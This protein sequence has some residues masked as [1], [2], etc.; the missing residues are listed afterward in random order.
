MRPADPHLTPQEL[1]LVLLS[2]A[3]PNLTTA[4][5]AQ[6]QEAQGHLERCEYCRSVAKQYANIDSALGRLR[7]GANPVRKKDCPEESVWL[8]VAAGL[9]DKGQ[10]AKLLEHA[11]QC[12]YCG[13]LLREAAEDLAA[14]PDKEIEAAVA[15]L[16]AAQ[17]DRQRALAAKLAK[18]PGAEGPRTAQEVGAGKSG[19][20]RPR[21]VWWPRLVWAAAGF[22]VLAVAA[23][24]G[25]KMLRQP[26]PNNL[27]AKAFTKKRTIEL[28]FPGAA[29]GPMRVERGSGN[30]DQPTEFYEAEVI[31]KRESGKHAEDPK[32]L[33][34]QAQAALLQW[35]YEAAI[36]NIEDALMFKPEDPELLQTKAMAYFERAE[37]LGPQA[38]I[39]YGEAAEDL[40]KALKKTPDDPVA[41]FNRAVI[42]DKIHLPNEAIKDLEHYLRVDPSGPWADEAKERLERLKKI[43]K[44]HDDALAEPLADPATFLRLM[45][46]PAAVAHID[47]R[48][49]DYQDLAIK[50]WLPAAFPTAGKTKSPEAFSALRAL[51]DIL[52]ERHKD[53]WLNDLLDGSSSEPAFAN[54]V[55]QLR[56]A[57][58]SSSKGDPTTAFRESV[59][60]QRSF[61]KAGSIPGYF[62]SEVEEVYSLQRAN[63]GENCRRRFKAIRGN[64]HDLSYKWASIQLEIDGAACLLKV[65]R[66][67]ESRRVLQQAITSLDGKYFNLQLRSIG[68]F[69]GIDT[70][71]GN[72]PETWK[73]DIAGLALYW[74]SALSA[75]MRAHQFYD[76][77]TYSAED[78]DFPN[79]ALSFA[80]ENV[81]AIAATS[82][83]AGQAFSRQ[84]LAELEQKANDFAEST[85]QF[86]LSKS[87]FNQLLQTPTTEAYRAESEIGIAASEID[88]GRYE[89]AAE[90]IDRAKLVLLGTR[91]FEVQLQFYEV[92]ADLLLRKGELSRAEAVLIDAI[93]LSDRSFMTL[94]SV[95]DR[96]R[97]LEEISSVYRSA[98]E[99]ELTKGDTDAA[100]ALWERYQAAPS[101]AQEGNPV[102]LS[103]LKKKIEEFP[104]RTNGR[105]ILIYA[106]LPRGVAV[107]LI[108]RDRVEFQRIKPDRDLASEGSHYFTLCSDSNSNVS[109]LRELGQSLYQQLIGPF[110]TQLRAKTRWIVELDP[111]IG[112]IPFDALITSDGEYLVQSTEITYSDGL[113]YADYSRVPQPITVNSA[114]VILRGEGV[115]GDVSE[116]ADINMEVEAIER[117][118]KH[119][120]VVRGSAVDSKQ[121]ETLLVNAEMFHYAGHA[122]STRIREGLLLTDSPSK[123]Q[124]WI[125]D[126]ED[127]VWG[128]RLQLVVLSACSTGNRTRSISQ[129][130]GRLLR[131]FV[132]VGTP[133]VITT[134][135]D[136]DSEATRV[137]MTSFYSFIVQGQAASSALA[138]SQRALLRRA[139][140]NHPFYWA[141]F[142]VVENRWSEENPS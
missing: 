90:R 111:K 103:R 94:N 53:K 93:E 131:M 114:A 138:H 87:L 106:V 69:A 25:V 42:Y 133:R 68:I 46:D 41:L 134:L 23:L 2:G 140:T 78:V 1:E 24:V 39:D 49:E 61:Q 116:S 92:Y 48:I 82:D 52:Q 26:D 10:S 22:A 89:S 137:L 57:V 115:P 29:Y 59:E 132:A 125:P 81:R 113:F 119:A 108:D 97:W 27:L 30:K 62:R 65:Q 95:I 16:A 44:A 9:A 11:A 123:R 12:D 38:A 56:E 64:L 110:S 8:E 33:Q 117:V 20:E 142:S 72:A 112:N 28:R 98:V 58:I 96:D 43:V 34:A 60:G 6:A 19:T 7:A 17:P 37:K 36:R 31:I 13:K 109:R 73:D 14:Q 77:L 5:R 3:G 45:G 130:R 75:P 99:L 71:E 136:I 129:E 74:N 54:G 122:I 139:A 104:K 88:Q 32:W 40:S 83:I 84:H 100:L 51:A 21:F 102:D 63:E 80:K 91:S 127:T 141:A 101:I 135:W 15:A 76:D 66:F 79:L 120:V 70:D 128:H 55:E 105:A 47:E 126:A 67:D 121:L 85:V 86:E 50:E 118:L 124:I 18:T 4:E 107:W 35:D